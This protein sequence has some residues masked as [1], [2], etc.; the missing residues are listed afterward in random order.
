[1]SEF[2]IAL[3]II[4]NMLISGEIYTTVGSEGRDKSHFCSKTKIT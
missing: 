2:N 4:E 1:M 3:L